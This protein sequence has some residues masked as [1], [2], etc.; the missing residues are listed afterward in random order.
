MLPVTVHHPKPSDAFA[1]V[2]VKETNNSVRRTYRQLKPLCFSNCCCSSRFF[3]VAS[4]IFVFTALVV[5]MGL[6]ITGHKNKAIA[7]GVLALTS[8]L[9][10]AGLIIFFKKIL[11]TLSNADCGYPLT[12][13]LLIRRPPREIIVRV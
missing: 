3:A 13:S 6:V 1:I 2:E 9:Y 12:C 7:A 11:C 4:G 10:C 8:L 5:S